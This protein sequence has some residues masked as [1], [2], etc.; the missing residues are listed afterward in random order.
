MS[1]EVDPGLALAAAIEDALTRMLPALES[2]PQV[3]GLAVA[4]EHLA[5]ALER[6][7][8]QLGA[9]LGQAQQALGGLETALSH[10]PGAAVELAAVRL[11]L[12]RAVNVAE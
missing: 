12:E 3:T 8:A 10:D 7:N 11:I 1:L 4:L 5:S 2:S 6:R 9:A